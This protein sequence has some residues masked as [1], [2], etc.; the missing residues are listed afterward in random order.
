VAAVKGRWSWLA[1]PRPV[2][3]NPAHRRNEIPWGRR[4]L[5]IGGFGNRIEGSINVDLFP[6]EGVD[7][8]CD[9]ERLPFQDEV[10]DRVDC[11]A[12]IEH[13]PSPQRLAAE[14]VRCLKPAGACHL[15]APFCHP[16]HE[17]PKDYYRFTLDGL[18]ELVKPLEVVS[19]G[20][21]TGPTSTMLVFFIEYVK[22]WLPSR[23]LRQAAWVGLGWLL[24]PLRYLD[25]FLLKSPRAGQLGNH[26]YIMARK[27]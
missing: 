5:Y 23:R 7:V 8:V 12:V 6:A 3:Y 17:Y 2:F 26:G 9:A 1:P 19:T 4:N 24:S 18:K 25:Y 27:K 13:T 16:F 21:M 20:W 22:L 11:D 15:A 14:I 10:F